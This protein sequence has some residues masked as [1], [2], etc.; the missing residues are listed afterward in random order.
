MGGMEKRAGRPSRCSRGHTLS[1]SQPALLLLLA[2]CGAIL[3]VP[4]DQWL[5]AH[6]SEPI[7]RDEKLVFTGRHGPV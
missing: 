5:T 3:K 4:P 7:L 6:G 2:V 1:R